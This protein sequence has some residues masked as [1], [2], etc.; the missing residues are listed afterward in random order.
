MFPA[1]KI[2]EYK[3]R[4]EKERA[5]LLKEVHENEKP[6]DFGDDTDRF[7]E[8]A[9]EAEEFSNRLAV[10]HALKM[11]LEE[12]ERALARIDEGTYGICTSCGAIIE[13]E[14]LAVS[15]ESNLCE[16]CKKGL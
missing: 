14:V 16:K 12:V 7:D 4:L 6:L 9:D 10:A 11:E 8:E 3:E 13:D 2:H 5:R 15:P 1:Q